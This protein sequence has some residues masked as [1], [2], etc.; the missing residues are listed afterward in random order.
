MENCKVVW[1]GKPVIKGEQLVAGVDVKDSENTHFVVVD[2]KGYVLIPDKDYTYDKDGYYDISEQ[3]CKVIVNA[4]GT[5][6]K[7]NGN[8]YGKAESDFVTVGTN[9]EQYVTEYVKSVV[10]ARDYIGKEITFDALTK[11]SA[12]DVAKAAGVKV[13]EVGFSD[14]LEMGV[15]FDITYKNNVDAY[16]L[17]DADG[18]L[19]AGTLGN[20][21][22]GVYHYS[23]NLTDSDVKNDDPQ[24]PQ[25]YLTFKGKYS[26]TTTPVRF[27]I[28]QRNINEVSTS[29]KV[30]F[31]PTATDANASSVYADQIEAIQFK[32]IPGNILKNTVDYTYDYYYVPCFFDGN[33]KLHE[34]VASKEIIQNI[35]DD[36]LR[37]TGK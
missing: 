31:N 33:Q 13:S 28:N 7:T 9:L 27:A 32:D 6:G 14:D 26:G 10:T 1:T 5:E 25:V 2:E 21:I 11:I 29:N 17:K 37:R 34:G 36:Y 30:I 4:T 24:A 22:N 20:Q 23:Q 18:N 12:A 8:Y 15:D 19:L 35:F 3:K 16:L